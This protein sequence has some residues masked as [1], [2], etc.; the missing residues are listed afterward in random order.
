V[1]RPRVVALVLNWCAEEDTATCVRSLER[2]GVA[3]L[4]ICIVDNASPDGSGTR[5]RARFPQHAYLDTGANLGYAGGN[6]RGCAWAVE[7]GAAFVLVINDDATLEPGA[8]AALLQVMEQDSTV[9]MAAPTVLHHEARDRSWWAGGRVIAHKA[10]GVAE[11][12]GEAPPAPT[13]PPQGTDFVSGC[14]VLLR[15]AALQRDGGFDPAY[16]SYLEDVELSVRWRL[17]G[18]RLVHVPAAV[19]THAVP[20]PP[21]VPSPFAIRLR[22]RNRRRFAARYLR[23]AQRLRFHL[24][25]WPTRVLL[26][27]RYLLGGDVPRAKAIAAGMWGR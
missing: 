11:H 23:G 14:A 25:Y 26:L 19:A 20:W 6:A 12:F 4:R 18:W 7:Q 3:G 15:A 9:G 8:L 24:W 22:D 13:Q 1:T 27:S 17:A 5:L 2:Q 21:P 10:I 16:V